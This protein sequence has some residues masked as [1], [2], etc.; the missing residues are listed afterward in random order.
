MNDLLY[1][2]ECPKCGHLLGMCMG[3]SAKETAVMIARWI[4]EG[5]R[6][7]GIS[8]ADSKNIS[9]RDWCKCGK[10]QQEEVPLALDLFLGE[11]HR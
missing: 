5:L 9:T 3:C 7:H 8:G 11:A 2:A 1:F 6:L 4:R 10:K